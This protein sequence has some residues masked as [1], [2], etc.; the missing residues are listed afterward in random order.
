[1]KEALIFFFYTIIIMTI[2]VI[3]GLTELYDYKHQ[4]IERGY[5]EFNSSTGEWQ[6]KEK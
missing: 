1:M 2:G 5:A 6:W 3:V 4:A